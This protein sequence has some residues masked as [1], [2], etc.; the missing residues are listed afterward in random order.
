MVGFLWMKKFP[1]TLPWA[2]VCE[3]VY[4]EA[5]E[6]LRRSGVC[7]SLWAASYFS[8]LVVSATPEPDSHKSAKLRSKQSCTKCCGPKSCC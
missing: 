3:R 5:P 4:S 7:E 8:V 1:S 6:M 2:G